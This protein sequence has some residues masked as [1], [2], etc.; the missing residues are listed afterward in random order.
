MRFHF[1]SLVLYHCHEHP[2][3]TY[4]A[5]RY[6]VRAPRIPAPDRYAL[7]WETPEELAAPETPRT[8]RRVCPLGQDLQLSCYKC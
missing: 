1:S 2:Y 7:A 4:P 5:L 3:L 8:L 6:G